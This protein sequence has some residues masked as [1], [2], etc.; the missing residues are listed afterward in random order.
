YG[1]DKPW[2]YDRREAGGGCLMDLGIHLVDLALWL[3]DPPVLSDLRARLF[4]AGKPLRHG[5]T[6]VEDY[7]VAELSCRSGAVIRIACSW[8]LPAGRDA[9]IEASLYGSKGGASMRN[10]EG[11]F[12]DFVAERYRG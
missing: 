5:D 6:A 4:A 2:F 8:H 7:A 1:P 9:V 3:L 11:S 12:Y 10:V